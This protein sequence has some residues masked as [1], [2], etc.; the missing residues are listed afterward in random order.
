MLAATSSSRLISHA[1][2]QRRIGAEPIQG[3]A[4]VEAWRTDTP[5]G[6]VGRASHD[7]YLARFGLIHT[8]VLTLAHDGARLDGLDRLAP[9]KGILRLKEDLAFAIAFHLLP[10][11]GAEREILEDGTACVRLALPRG[12]AWML[13]VRGAEIAVEESMHLADFAGPRRAL[14]AVLRGRTAGDTVVQWQLRR[15]S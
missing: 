6:L 9:P 2:L 7:G 13:S 1:R 5:D 12:E 10:G 15:Q 14:K 3:P 8:R 11:V 4:R